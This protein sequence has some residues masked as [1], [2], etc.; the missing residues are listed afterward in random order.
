[1]A[2]KDGAEDEREVRVTRHDGRK[3]GEQTLHP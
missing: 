3:G 2:R 1:V